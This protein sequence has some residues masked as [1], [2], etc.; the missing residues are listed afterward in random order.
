[1]GGKTHTKHTHK[2]QLWYIESHNPSVSVVTIIMFSADYSISMSPAF[3]PTF[4]IVATFALT[5]PVPLDHRV[6]GVHRVAPASAVLVL[7]RILW[8]LLR[9]VCCKCKHT[10]CLLWIVDELTTSDIL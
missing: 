4:D 9:T 8:A 5:D 10:R 3:H 1:M 7:N 6:A 2:K